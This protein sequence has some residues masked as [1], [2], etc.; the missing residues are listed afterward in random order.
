MAGRILLDEGYNR[1]VELSQS[2]SGAGS[3][4]TFR[5]VIASFGNLTSVYLYHIANGQDTI[6]FDL[7]FEDIETLH[8]A[9]QEYKQAIAQFDS[10]A[11]DDI[12]DYPF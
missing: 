4:A 9:L 8:A 5:Q 1:Q 2:V 3:Y 11:T 6:V 10:Q 12:G 7:S